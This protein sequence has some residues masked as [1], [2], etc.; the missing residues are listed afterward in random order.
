M[1]QPVSVSNSRSHRRAWIFNLYMH[2]SLLY[3]FYFASVKSF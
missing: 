2:E 1:M 3:G